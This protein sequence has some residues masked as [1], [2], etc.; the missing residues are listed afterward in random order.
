MTVHIRQIFTHRLD[1]SVNIPLCFAQA[2]SLSKSSYSG[3]FLNIQQ[4]RNNPFERCVCSKPI[5]SA[6]HETWLRECR[7]LGLLENVDFIQ[8]LRVLTLN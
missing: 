1:E 3:S 5:N 4:V 7:G 8:Q 2:S 6:S